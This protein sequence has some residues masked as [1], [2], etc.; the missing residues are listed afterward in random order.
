MAIP[1]A[2]GNESRTEFI[3]RPKFDNQPPEARL[4]AAPSETDD[5]VWEFDTSD[6]SDPDGDP[7][8]YF[9]DFGDGYTATGETAT[10]KYTTDAR[11]TVTLTV[12][13]QYGGKS[14]AQTMIS[15]PTCCPDTE[16]NNNEDTCGGCGVTTGGAAWPNAAPMLLALL[17][18]IC[19]RFSR[20]SRRHG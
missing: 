5:S 20:K 9:W 12:L 4:A 17:A 18:M 2:A 19:L 8:R 14:S 13:D 15:P 6:S 11:A 1:V 10:H 7:L 16:H 3:A